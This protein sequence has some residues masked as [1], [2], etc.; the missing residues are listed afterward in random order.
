MLGS[1]DGRWSR[2]APVIDL[3]RGFRRPVAIGRGSL[4]P[5]AGAAPLS[6]AT[7]PLRLEST[8]KVGVVARRLMGQPFGIGRYIQYLLTYWARIA[9]P[10]DRFVLYAPGPLESGRVPASDLFRD[11]VIGPDIQGTL[12]EN[13]LLPKSVQGIAVLV[14]PSYTIT[15]AL[16]RPHGWGDPQRQRGPAGR[17]RLDLSLD[18]HALPEQRPPRNPGH[19][20][21]R[22]HHARR[23]AVARRAGGPDR[24]RPR[25]SGRGIQA[26]R[27][28]RATPAYSGEV[29]RPRPSLPP[30]R[31]EAFAAAQHS[32]IGPGVGPTEAGARHTAWTEP[33]SRRA[34]LGVGRLRGR[35]A[36]DRAVPRSHGHHRFYSAA[37]A[38]VYPSAYDGFSLTVVEAMAAEYR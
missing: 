4:P 6:S 10:E 34:D 31:R 2:I 29:L 28:Y 21:V 22:G 14:G 13:V 17:T 38:H 15:T 26:G 18:V 19:R 24:H 32:R 30:V 36:G 23:A 25:G 8:M 1:I 27:G 16:P 3:A 12:W 33:P 7:A 20:A 37:D 9:E 35:G 11:D 5:P